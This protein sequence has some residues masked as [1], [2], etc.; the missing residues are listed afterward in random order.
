MKY[1]GTVL[2]MILGLML[3]SVA[4]ARPRRSELELY[5]PG[6]INGVLVDKGT[7]KVEFSPDMSTFTLY[8]A[9][10]QVASAPCDVS[11]LPEGALGSS[12]AYED[13]A[14]GREKITRIV[15]YKPGVVIRIKE[16]KS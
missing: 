5:R 8:R 13:A 11:V 16:T 14:G 12:V 15:L 3:S 9:D 6:T 2:V 10:E 4:M 1:R 7:Y